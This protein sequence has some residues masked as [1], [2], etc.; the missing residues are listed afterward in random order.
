MLTNAVLLAEETG[1]LLCLLKGI[2]GDGPREGSWRKRLASVGQR[3]G[4]VAWLKVL[5]WEMAVDIW[6]GSDLLS[7]QPPDDYTGPLI[8]WRLAYDS[9]LRLLPRPPP[10][11]PVPAPHAPPQL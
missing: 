4:T 6:A 9:L 8:S 5:Q 11:S 1:H 10:S 2:T 7:R 3:L